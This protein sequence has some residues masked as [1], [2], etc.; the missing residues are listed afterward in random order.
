M[1]LLLGFVVV[2]VEEHQRLDRDVQQEEEEGRG[3]NGE[4]DARIF[5]R[6]IHLIDLRIHCQ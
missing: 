6:I 2:V 5:R 1:L 3:N 4:P